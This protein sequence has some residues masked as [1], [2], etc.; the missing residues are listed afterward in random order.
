MFLFDTHLHLDLFPQYSE[1]ISEIKKHSIPTIAMTNA[2]SVFNKSC[3][4]ASDCNYINTAL[5]FHPELIKQ[6]AN[7]IQLFSELIDRTKY[8]GEV[9]LDYSNISDNEKNI[10][11]RIFE[12]I[13][14]LCTD[15]APKTLS[16]HSRMAISD[17]IEIIGNEFN[18]KIILHWF[19]GSLTLLAKALKNRYFFSINYVMVSSERG[20]RIVREIPLDNL[21]LE[22]DGPFIK[23]GNKP[24]T[25]L[26]NKLILER[27]AEI[28]NVDIDSVQD[29]MRKN[30][31]EISDS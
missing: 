3:E 29:Y 26:H 2:P 18:G 14:K 27:I 6:R 24:A 4:I 7:E 25:P 22:S 21:L 12:K 5:G 10:Q 23:I 15:K 8:I 16:I 9:G 17:V 20:I 19:S 30:F 1:V 11:K 13:L 28:K 31:L